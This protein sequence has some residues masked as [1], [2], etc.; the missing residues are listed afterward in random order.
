[1]LNAGAISIHQDD[2]ERTLLIPL[3]DNEEE[4]V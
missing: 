3:F 1:M 4:L 2:K